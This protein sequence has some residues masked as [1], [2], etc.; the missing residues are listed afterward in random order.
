MSSSSL[1]LEVNLSRVIV[2]AAYVVS[3]ALANLSLALSASLRACSI[4]RQATFSSARAWAAS[5]RADFSLDSAF[6]AA[7]S[8]ADKVT[9]QGSINQ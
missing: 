9:G 7:A 5:D 2:Y 6:C 1:D 3:S 8:C 4:A